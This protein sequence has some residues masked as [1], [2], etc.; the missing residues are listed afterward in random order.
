[1]AGLLLDPASDR[2]ADWGLLDVADPCRQ[3]NGPQVQQAFRDFIWPLIPATPSTPG[4]S[5]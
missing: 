4:P 1:M 3:Q 2:W 5:A